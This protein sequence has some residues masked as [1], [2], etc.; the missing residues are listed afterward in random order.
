M[1]AIASQQFDEQ[2]DNEKANLYIQ[3]ENN[4]ITN[5]ESKKH[6]STQVDYISLIM[7]K[8]SQEY[9]DEYTKSRKKLQQ[10]PTIVAPPLSR[11]IENIHQ[12]NSLTVHS[13]SDSRGLF[14]DSLKNPVNV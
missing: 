4:N 11:N 12:V 2:E 8:N 13:D 3:D 1:A 14:F 5:S 9:E 10:L 7:A 6:I